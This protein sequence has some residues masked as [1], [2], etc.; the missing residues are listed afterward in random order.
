ME[1]IDLLDKIL[2]EPMDKNLRFELL[3]NL[4]INTGKRTTGI[5]EGTLQDLLWTRDYKVDASK[6][7]GRTLV[8]GHTRTPLFEVKQSLA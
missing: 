4:F 8:T 5:T 1:H 7:G 6:L 3:R 2:A